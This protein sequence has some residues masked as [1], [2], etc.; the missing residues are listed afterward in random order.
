MADYDV[1]ILGAGAAGM[2]AGIEASRRGRKVLV[3]DHARDPG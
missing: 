2:M 1:I 3:V